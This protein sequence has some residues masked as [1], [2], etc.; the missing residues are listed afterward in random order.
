MTGRVQ[1]KS[2]TDMSRSEVR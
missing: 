2:V 1:N